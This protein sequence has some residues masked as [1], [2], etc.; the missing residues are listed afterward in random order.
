MDATP[1]KDKKLKKA[2]RKSVGGEDVQGKSSVKKVKKTKKD[3][4]T[5]VEAEGANGRVESEEQAGEKEVST[6]AEKKGEGEDVQSKMEEGRKDGE[7]KGPG[8]K[9]TVSIAL[10]GSIISNAQTKAL[11]S[12]L[13]G[14]VARAAAV[15]NV[16]EIVV[17]KEEENPKLLAKQE[18][19]PNF[20]LAHNLQYLETPQYLRKDFFPR[21][22]SL[23]F[24]GVM[25]PVDAPHHLRAS[26]ESKYREGVVLNKPVK[27]G[28]G[29]FINI[30]LRKECMVNKHIK[31]GVRVTVEVLEEQKKNYVG[32][33]VSPAQPR[34]QDGLYWGYQTRIAP[35]LNAAMSSC[36]FEGGYDLVIGTSERGEDIQGIE[37]K[38]FKHL[39]VVFGGLGGLEVSLD[40]QD[41]NKI[42]SLFHH[43]V[44]TCPGQGSRTIRTEEAV[45]ITMTALK[46]KIG[47]L[48]M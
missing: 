8:R 44:N 48:D 42:A 2:K 25:N 32:R 4:S 24:A 17:F 9:Y 13:A 14:Q 37:M 10:P 16:D 47:K 34:E 23:E 11:K 43:Y 6:K 29:S 12:Y 18:V 26:E 22:D 7:E 27:K 15:F 19:D 33:V 1:T 38:P 28:H 39:L 20:F 41:T 5:E 21:H 40:E 3:T 36:P 35:N 45:L 46:S 31:P 30:G